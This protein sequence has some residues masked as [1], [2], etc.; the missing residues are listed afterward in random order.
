MQAQHENKEKVENKFRLFKNIL[1][2]PW[3]PLIFILI[4]PI[5]RLLY[6][7][8]VFFFVGAMD[9]AL[10][11]AATGVFSNSTALW[12]QLHKAGTVT[13]DRMWRFPLWEHFSKRV[14]GKTCSH[15]HLK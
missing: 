4:L 3:V 6:P 13:G 14:T 11:Q 1:L 7:L 10:G 2:I 15:I 12:E 8:N 9:V 5:I